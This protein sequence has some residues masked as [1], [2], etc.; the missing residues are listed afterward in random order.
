MSGAVP[1]A[2]IGEYRAV[3][4]GNATR[5]V[6]VKASGSYSTVIAWAK[7]S[8]DRQT[9]FSTE[10]RARRHHLWPTEPGR[11]AGSLPHANGSGATTRSV[12]VPQAS[13]DRIPDQAG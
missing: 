1:H 13:M 10:G 9:Q 5:L 12:S 3:K 2:V 4:V 6:T 7:G 11:G 8:S